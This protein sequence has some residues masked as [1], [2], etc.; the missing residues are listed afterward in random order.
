MRN[1]ERSIGRV[2]LNPACKNIHKQAKLNRVVWMLLFVV[3]ESV[4]E[5]HSKGRVS[6]LS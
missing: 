2:G 3:E 4:A 6:R 5:G 1:H